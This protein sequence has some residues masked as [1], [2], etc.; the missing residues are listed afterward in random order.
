MKK[1]NLGKWPRLPSKFTRLLSTNVTSQQCFTINLIIHMD[2]QNCGTVCFL[3]LVTEH[4]R[5][6]QEMPQHKHTGSIQRWTEKTKKELTAITQNQK[7]RTSINSMKYIEKIRSRVERKPT[8]PCASKEQ[9][10]CYQC[11]NSRFSRLLY[12]SWLMNNVIEY[13][14]TKSS[15]EVLTEF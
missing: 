3:E 14:T 9:R 15:V 1:T 7:L 4:I 8:W 10:I 12:Q 6:H 13:P 5:K 11:Q 2:E